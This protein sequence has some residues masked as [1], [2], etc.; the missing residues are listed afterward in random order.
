[1]SEADANPIRSCEMRVRAPDRPIK[2]RDETRRAALEAGAYDPARRLR[3]VAV[4]PSREVPMKRPSIISS[5]LATTIVVFAACSPKADKDACTK[6]AEHDWGIV[7]QRNHMSEIE[8]GK[9][10]LE[11]AKVKSVQA[12]TGKWTQAQVECHL[13]ATTPTDM[14][15]CDPKE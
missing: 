7:D 14:D 10:L 9:K 1:V 4:N 15:A 5:L 13:K 6:M 2:K 12:C 11:E 3:P 8:S